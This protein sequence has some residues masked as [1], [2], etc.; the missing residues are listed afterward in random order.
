MPIHDQGY[1]RYGGQRGALGRGWMIIA[2]HHLRTAVKY[3]PF[4]ILLIACWGQFVVQSVRA[5]ISSAY[6]VPEA[7]QFS[8]STYRDFLSIQGIGVF[9]VSIA[10]AGLIADD[11][12]ANALQV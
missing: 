10:M 8:A 3:R 5:Y 1:R 9:L 4:I 6:P 7:I 2:K 11:K 12:R